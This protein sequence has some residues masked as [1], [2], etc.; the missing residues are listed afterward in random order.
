[1]KTIVERYLS[2]PNPIISID[3]KKKEY[4]GNFIVKEN[5]IQRKNQS[6]RP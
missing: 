6:E 3:G 5:C 1:M 2:S 4:L